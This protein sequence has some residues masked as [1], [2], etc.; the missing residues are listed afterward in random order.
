MTSCRLSSVI[1]TD[2][3]GV[4]MWLIDG[5]LLPPLRLI[6]GAPL[7]PQ[8]PPGHTYQDAPV[9]ATTGYTYLGV[10]VDPPTSTINKEHLIYLL[11]AFCPIR[12]KSVELSDKA[13]TS[14]FG[15]PQ[16][17]EVIISVV[18]ARMCELTITLRLDLASSCLFDPLL[19]A[20]QERWDSVDRRDF[21]DDLR[22]L[23]GNREVELI[24]VST[25]VTHHSWVVP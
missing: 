7:P 9:A 4:P 5:P 1:V 19:D 8:L 12:I 2:C 20:F 16:K 24:N 14:V 13:M 3:A 25:S 6:D 18:D 21:C 17:K 15:L 10:P 11:R 23:I 22:G